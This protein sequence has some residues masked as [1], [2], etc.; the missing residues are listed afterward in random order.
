M[1]LKNPLYGHILRYFNLWP[2]QILSCSTRPATRIYSCEIFVCVLFKLSLQT[3]VAA[4]TKLGQKI[5]DV[6]KNRHQIKQAPQNCYTLGV[7]RNFHKTFLN[8]R[9]ENQLSLKTVVAAST[10]NWHQIKQTFKIS[11]HF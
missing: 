9:S 7:S 1:L 10:K 8:E 5:M 11:I 4:S 2:S 3:V 6:T